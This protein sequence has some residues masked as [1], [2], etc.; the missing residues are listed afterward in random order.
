VIPYK[1]MQKIEIER[2][3][4]LPPGIHFDGQGNSIWSLW[5]RSCVVIHRRMD[6]LRIG[7]NDAKNLARFLEGKAGQSNGK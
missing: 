4:F 7:T 2:W 3:R 6:I 5:G 1:D